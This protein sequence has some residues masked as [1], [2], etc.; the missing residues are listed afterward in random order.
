MVL[1]EEVKNKRSICLGSMASRGRIPGGSVLRA[2]WGGVLGTVGW[3][4]LPW[5]WEGAICGSTGDGEWYFVSLTEDS[6]TE[7][8]AGNESDCEFRFR[9]HLTACRRRWM[10]R[11]RSWW[12]LMAVVEQN[13][14]ISKRPLHF[15]WKSAIAP[16][17][18]WGG[19]L[20]AVVQCYSKKR[21]VLHA[22]LLWQCCGVLKKFYIHYYSDITSHPSEDIKCKGVRSH[23]DAQWTNFESVEPAAVT[24]HYCRI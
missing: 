19:R 14:A 1:G 15:T 8:E 22:V 11:W 21:S 2:W 17:L 24:R 7:N 23:I 20:V 3:K 12:L 18:T 9:L 13:T 5:A 6:C 16:F 10:G 4:E